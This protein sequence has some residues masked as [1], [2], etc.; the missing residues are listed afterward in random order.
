M[1]I[2]W[3]QAGI[4]KEAWKGSPND[5]AFAGHVDADPQLVFWP[6]WPERIREL[7]AVRLIDCDRMHAIARNWTAVAQPSVR[8]M[9]DDQC[10]R[11]HFDGWALARLIASELCA[12]EAIE[13]RDGE[14]A[15]LLI[16]AAQASSSMTIEAN[17]LAHQSAHTAMAWQ[18]DGPNECVKLMLAR[19]GYRV[20]SASEHS[21]EYPDRRGQTWLE[22]RQ[23]PRTDWLA[24]AKS[25]WSARRG[26]L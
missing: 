24:E 19:R 1:I 20:C 15:A 22:S 17:S 18:Y 2:N 5:V 9:S 26:A 14:E 25:F 10:S 7:G 12:I 4:S 8:P 16:E 3:Y 6:T 11:Y 23:P 13:R 21:V